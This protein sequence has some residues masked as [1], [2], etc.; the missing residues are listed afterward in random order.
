MIRPEPIARRP[1]R[2]RFA[3]VA[4]AVLTMGAFVA[5]G[6]TMLHAQG[7]VE[8]AQKGAREGNKAAG[9]IGGVLGGAIGGV[10][11]AVGGVVGAVTGGGG[12]RPLHCRGIDR[13]GRVRSEKVDREGFVCALSDLVGKFDDRGGI[14]VGGADGAQRVGSRC[15]YHQFRR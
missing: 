2:L 8:G 1:S 4:F 6:S 13:W 3:A 5:A 12:N 14:G 11:G 9:P 15:C 10:V 7:L